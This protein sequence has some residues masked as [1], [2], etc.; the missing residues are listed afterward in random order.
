MKHAVTR[1]VLFVVIL[2][3]FAVATC[4]KKQPERA[5]TL[6][7]PVVKLVS[8][9]P[10][11]A[12]WEYMWR[13]WEPAKID[14]DFG[15]IRALGF[16]TVRLFVPAD[17]FG[18]PAPTADKLSHLADAV[19]MAQNHHLRVQLT[20][21]D[22]WNSYTRISASKQWAH[23]IVAPFH[24]DGRIQSIE[25]K[26]EIDPRIASAITW[27]KVLLPFVRSEA[28]TLP[29]TVSAA[30][31]DVG[32]L[33]MLRDGLGSGAQPD[34]YSYHYYGSADD[35]YTTFARARDV[36]APV[37]LVIGETGYSTGDASG[38]VAPD[39]TAELEQ[40][41]FLI[42]VERAAYKL[43]L[44]TAGVWIYSDFVPG[45]LG[46]TPNKRYHFGLV[47]ADGTSK[48]IAGWIKTFFAQIPDSAFLRP[49][50]VAIS[51]ALSIRDL[52]ERARLFRLQL[53]GF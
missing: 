26:N 20:L 47:R 48:P 50:P 10:N 36:V 41:K 38:A 37:R 13:N 32:F 53:A 30:V 29:V 16:N 7:R 42:T 25:L 15:S 39:A 24:N 44:G 34:F 17:E 51:T 52:I 31:G 40:Q 43:G 12:G 5:N 8:Y 11:D 1:L 4:T 2:S 33:R 3:V 46:P 19:T 22:L 23:A 9:F 49:S 6:L 45:A 27:A 14:G 18:F 35:A 21:F 28:G